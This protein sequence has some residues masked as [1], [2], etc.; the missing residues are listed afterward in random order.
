MTDTLVEDIAVYPLIVDLSACLCTALEEAGGPDLCYCGPQ[1]G[2]LVLDFCG[3][4]CDGEGCGGQAWVRLVDA[5]PS[6]VFPSQDAILTN[7][8]SPWAFSL[9]IGVA[10]C[11]PMGDA[12]GV[13][14]YDPP[15]M[16]Q[17]LAAMRLQTSDL[18]AMRRA[19]TCCFGKT[20]RDYMVGTYSQA[21]VNQGGCLGGSITVWV[22]E[23]F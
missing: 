18:A 7:C 8:R 19:V 4:G 6:S 20:D 17:N 2:E 22:R 23:E 13:G 15:T 16:E 11:A 12:N 5:F 9:E 10:R 1:V 3:G 14:G 21:L